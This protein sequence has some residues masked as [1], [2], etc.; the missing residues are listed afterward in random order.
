MGF[1]E[2]W[3]RKMPS[4]QEQDY[5]VVYIPIHMLPVVRVE[6]PCDFYCA[7]TIHFYE[8]IFIGLMLSFNLSINRSHLACPPA[9]TA[10]AAH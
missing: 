6:K 10:A 8:C 2:K 9:E 1:L 5:W 3:Q 4:K 7:V